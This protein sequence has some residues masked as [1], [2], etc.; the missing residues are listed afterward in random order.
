MLRCHWLLLSSLL[1]FL[2]NECGST[3]A[4]KPDPTK[5]TVTGIVH[6]ADT[7][8]PARFAEVTLVAEPEEGDYT[9]HD[10]NGVTGLDG[11]FKIMNVA[12]G[13][14]Y[15]VAEL[16]GYLSIE[17]GYDY[18]RL[19]GHA[20]DRE[21]TLD[22]IDQWKDHLAE[23][24]VEAHGTADLS[25][26]VE[27]GAE[28]HGTVTYDDGNPAIGMHF[29]LFRKTEKNN[30]INVGAPSDN[31]SISAVSDGHGHFNLSNL[32]AGEYTVCASMPV[33]NPNEAPRVCL[34]NTFR[35]RD[36][37]TFNVQAGEIAAGADIEIPLSGLH[38]VTGTVSA[39]ADSHALKDATVRLL[40]GDDREIAREVKSLD[41]GS[42]SF[43]YVPE[44]TYILQVSGAREAEQKAS[45]T[46]SSNSGGAASKTSAARSYADKELSIPVQ[47]DVDDLKVQLVL[48]PPDKP[49]E[50]PPAPAP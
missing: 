8:K 39:L 32:P 12:P 16:E 3:S 35:K 11:R 23:I 24:M 19:G 33:G 7:G 10:E 41:D 31:W 34:G 21:Q 13:H 37:K 9:P 20:S 50:P 14:Y 18:T 4:I 42:Y 30:W 5:G 38:T 45:E 28:I 47:G 40:Y 1:C 2:S 43:A 44:G 15:A 49:A 22:M 46:D 27:R 29:L 48:I 17:R 26:Q 36:A 6:C 25:M